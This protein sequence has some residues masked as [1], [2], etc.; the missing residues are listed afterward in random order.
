MAKR[1]YVS[2]LKLKWLLGLFTGVV[3]FHCTWLV[4]TAHTRT[5]SPTIP[6]DH[7]QNKGC[8]PHAI[9]IGARKGGTRG[10]LNFINIHPDV[11]AAERELHYFD[12]DT[13]Y[14]R[15]VDWYKSR[16]PECHPGQIVIEK[17][18]AYFV[19]KKAPGRIHNMNKTIKLLLILRNPIDRAI[20]DY[21]QLY[22]KSISSSVAMGTFEEMVLHSNKH[23]INLRYGP[24]VTSVYYIFLI[25]WLK[26]FPRRQLHVVD[27]EKFVR[28]PYSEIKKVESFLGLSHK[29][30][31]D[32][33]VFNETKGFYCVRE[34]Y[35]ST[36]L[37]ENKG[38]KHPPVKSE[39][40]QKLVK[41]YSPY[42]EALYH[43]LGQR[44]NW[45]AYQ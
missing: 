14:Q 20:S 31:E 5:I 19:S 40:L 26:L 32:S 9:I 34:N 30:S 1:K 39:I 42:N 3:C 27:G 12:N 16:L 45:S 17:T 11:I 33:F 6:G 38:R 10:L 44:F 24:V 36:C 23:K 18:P 25:R 13:I 37:G 22:Q 35:T 21:L 29:I 41:L 28:Q 43:R 8:L 2:Q 4:Y 7:K 15:G